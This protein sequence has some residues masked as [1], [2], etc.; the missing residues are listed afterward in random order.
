MLGAQKTAM[1]LHQKHGCGRELVGRHRLE[2]WT[3]GL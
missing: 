2:L 3:K 1:Q